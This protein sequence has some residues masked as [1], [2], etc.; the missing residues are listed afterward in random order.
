MLEQIVGATEV[1]Y[2]DTTA[3]VVTPDKETEFFDAT[4]DVLGDTLAPCIY[5]ITMDYVMKKR[6]RFCI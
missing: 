4:A 2:K 3:Y 1:L 5:I 6:I